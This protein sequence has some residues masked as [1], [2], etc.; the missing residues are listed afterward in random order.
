VYEALG[1]VRG[2]LARRP[3]HVR[4][5]VVFLNPYASHKEK[6]LAPALL[7]A[8]LQQLP[9]ECSGLDLVVPSPPERVSDGDVAFFAQL[10]S[11]L[12]SSVARGVTNVRP[13]M[14]LD[15]Y[16]R[17]VASAACVVGPDSSTQ[18]IAAVVGTPSIAVYPPES[19]FN[20]NVWSALGESSICFDMPSREAS[21]ALCAVASLVAM[22]AGHLARN[23]V[24]D[25][26]P[27]RFEE[28]ALIEEWRR[29][30]RRED[31]VEAGARAL[32]RTERAVRAALPDAWSQIVL[33][34]L[35]WTFDRLCSRVEATER[36]DNVSLAELE[37]INACN[38][39]RILSTI[40][41]AGA[42]RP[43][44]GRPPNG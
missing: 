1:L 37:S 30:G 10:D 27:N 23:G 20:F 12:R 43:R 24:P 16:V 4:E 7:D 38:V 32:A 28:R 44:R 25:A 36:N 35:R 34:E 39:L 29:V 6:C 40:P 15:E 42:G 5:Q 9:A 31:A 8:L 33:T 26:A 18:H 21:P 11:L 13:P 41:T 3:E 2:A 19:N 22:L 17:T 14:K